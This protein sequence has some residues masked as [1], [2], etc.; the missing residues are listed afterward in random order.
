MKELMKSSLKFAL[1]LFVILG[2]IGAA[3]LLWVLPSASV[4]FSTPTELN[5]V[6]I[7]SDMDGIY[8]KA[9]LSDLHGS[10]YT[11]NVKKSTFYTHVMPIDDTH[12]IAVRISNVDVPYENR[13]FE[14]G[15]QL[16]EH[17]EDGNQL[18]SHQYVVSG[19]LYKMDAEDE[20]RYLEYIASGAI[21]G[22]DTNHA[23]TYY[24][25][26]CDYGG[27]H[28]STSIYLFGFV[29]IAALFFGCWALIA[30]LLGANQKEIKKYI[31]NSASPE[32]TTRSIENFLVN[33]PIIND[34][35]YN[36]Q[37][38]CYHPSGNVH[39]FNETG[40]MIWAYKVSDRTHKTKLND[41]LVLQEHGVLIYFTDGKVNQCTFKSQEQA[42]EA[43]ANL[44]A[45]CPKAVIG[46][47]VELED[48]MEKNLDGFLRMTY[49]STKNV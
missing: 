15:E 41:K 35:Q 25:D 32:G 3:S 16:I 42:D 48:I 36:E 27:N 37:F 39:F 46:Y 43:I 13:F 33:A 11:Y 2:I 44:E 10:Y 21:P 47:A 8:V 18:S 5:E 4:L 28:N 20:A 26:V 14:S 40:K 29:G 31:R 30:A 34:F 17:I 24:L 6:D 9:T 19:T 49:Y 12:Y 22:I 23:L 7:D 38:L 45:L 1:V